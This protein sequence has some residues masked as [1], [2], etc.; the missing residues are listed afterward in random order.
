MPKEQ[1]PTNEILNNEKNNAGV[2]MRIQNNEH[3]KGIMRRLKGRT[4]A[5]VL[6]AAI[7]PTIM[8]GKPPPTPEAQ[9]AVKEAQTSKMIGKRAPTADADF[10][11]KHAQTLKSA[12]EKSK[13]A[14]ERLE[15]MKNGR[16]VPEPSGVATPPGNTVTARSVQ[17][18][19]GLG[20]NRAVDI[21]LPNF[22]QSPNLRKFVDG[23]PQLG[24][25]GINN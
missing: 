13:E 3:P 23:L 18:P 8:I 22:A 21:N 17:P 6:M 19:V 9:S 16:P 20:V 15:A 14:R 7:V 1:S 10:E 12:R 11:F 25:A 5:T 4:F 24:P 2:I